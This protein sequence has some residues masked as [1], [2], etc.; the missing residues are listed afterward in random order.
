MSRATCG[1]AQRLDG[2]ITMGRERFT[3]SGL[4]GGRRSDGHDALGT[5]RLP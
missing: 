5:N 1:A 4:G 2:T 3:R